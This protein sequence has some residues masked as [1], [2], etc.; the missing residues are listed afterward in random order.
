[1]RGKDELLFLVIDHS[2]DGLL[3]KLESALAEAVTPKAKLLALIRTHLEFAFHHG[4]ALKV[5]N[6]DIETLAE[7]HRTAAATKR[8]SYLLRGLEVLRALDP[9]ARADDQ[10]L[11]AT[12]LLLGML[13]GIATRPFMAPSATFR[14]LADVVKNLFLYG[15]LGTGRDSEH[16]AP[17]RI[18][19]PRDEEAA[20][21]S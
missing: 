5:I 3:D 12:N 13:N 20:H 11:D 15:F 19:R 18:A 14:S 9:H 17:A 6:R 4:S 7:P 8:H 10:L 16:T 1:M 21:V 2:L